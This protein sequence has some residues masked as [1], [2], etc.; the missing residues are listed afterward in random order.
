MLGTH[1]IK[2]CCCPFIKDEKNYINI[3]HSCHLKK[4]LQAWDLYTLKSNKKKSKRLSSKVSI[5]LPPSL[6]FVSLKKICVYDRG[7]KFK[8]FSTLLLSSTP[9]TVNFIPRIFDDFDFK[10]FAVMRC[11]LTLFGLGFFG[12]FRSRGVDSASA[13]IT[14]VWFML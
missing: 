13:S 12:R 4:L 10:K 11:S 3:H 5:F 8:Y 14:F 7:V 1:I 9:V 6:T 2:L